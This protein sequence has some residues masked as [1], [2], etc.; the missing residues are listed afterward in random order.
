[1]GVILGKAFSKENHYS[2]STDERSRSKCLFHSTFQ[3]PLSAAP[4]SFP[5]KKY[6]P[7]EAAAHL[8]TYPPQRLQLHQ[9]CSKSRSRGAAAPRKQTHAGTFWAP[10]AHSLFLPSSF[11][12][13]RSR[14]DGCVCGVP[15]LQQHVRAYK[16]V[17]VG[18]VCAVVGP[19]R[20]FEFHS[21][22]SRLVVTS[23]LEKWKKKK[24]QNKIGGIKQKAMKEIYKTI[25][26]IITYSVPNDHQ[27][28]NFLLLF[29][30]LSPSLP[31]AVLQWSRRSPKAPHM[32]LICLQQ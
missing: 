16:Y 28:V 20:A 2:T 22:D 6:R 10:A 3:T 27:C 7:N 32:A 12:W 11:R 25:N 23:F 19:F 13:I 21:S 14:G 29:L 24:Q 5:A 18:G 15:S 31:S 4:A 17:C 9:C 1:M 26:V 8:R 30:S